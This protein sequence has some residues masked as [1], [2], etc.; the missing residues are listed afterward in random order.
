[1]EHHGGVLTKKSK[2]VETK[3]M[4]GNKSEVERLKL[5]IIEMLKMDEFRHL[6]LT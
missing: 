5:Q 3:Y 2:S 6:G 1:M 4:C